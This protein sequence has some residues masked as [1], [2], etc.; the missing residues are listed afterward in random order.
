MN[1][2]AL[3]QVGTGG[4]REHRFSIFSETGELNH[5][6]DV[7]DAKCECACFLVSRYINKPFTY[8][9]HVKLK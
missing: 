8:S 2:G 5:L 6:L 4:T 7:C 3:M 1:A 9:S